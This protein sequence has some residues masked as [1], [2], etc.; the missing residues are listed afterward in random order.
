MKI[1]IYLTFNGQCEEAMNFY[2]KALGGILNI[3]VFRDSPMEVPESYKDQVMHATL[4]I[5]DQ[6]LMASDSMPGMPLLPG[7]NFSV[8]L[9]FPDV[10]SLEAAFGKISE[11]GVITMPL[12]EMFWNARFGMCTDKFGI[13]WMF[14]H[15]Y[16]Q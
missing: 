2:H 6:K 12:G 4:E 16:P 5:G 1:L 9:D 11:G 15:D 8:S 7:N 10:A 14:N 3:Q 13:G